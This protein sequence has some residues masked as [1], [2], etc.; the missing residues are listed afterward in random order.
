MQFFYKL[1]LS[2]F[3]SKTQQLQH[4]TGRSDGC[5]VS[6]ISIFNNFTIN[7]TKYILVYKLKGIIIYMI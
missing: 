3:K 6:T 2:N 1:N 4:N 7:Y 5:L